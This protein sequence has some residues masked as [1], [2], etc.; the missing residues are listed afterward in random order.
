MPGEFDRN[1]ENGI[2]STGILLMFTKFAAKVRRRDVIKQFDSRERGSRERLASSVLDARKY[3]RRQPTPS[4]PPAAT[5]AVELFIRVIELAISIGDT[6]RKR[7]F[8]RVSG[9]LQP[10]TPWETQG[11]Y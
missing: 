5:S 9:T 7:Q 6:V 4:T 2:F 1:N 10:A 8:A 11:M 3:T